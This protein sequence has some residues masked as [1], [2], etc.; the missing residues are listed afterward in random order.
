M[1][2]SAEPSHPNN[3]AEEKVRRV[4]LLISA[5]LRTGVVLSMVLIVGGTILSFLHH[6]AYLSSS[7]EFARLTRPGAAFPHTLAEVADCV[8]HWRGKA[9]VAAGLLVLIATPV[10]RVAVSIFGFLYQKDHTF[11]V[12]TTIVLALLLLSFVLGRVEH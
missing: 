10:M 4:E 1:N 2:H 12:L 6:P 8:Q 11:V 3:P 5:L 7:D 9:I